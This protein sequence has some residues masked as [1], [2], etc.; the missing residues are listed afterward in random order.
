[1]DNV[2]YTC[3]NGSLK[4]FVRNNAKRHEDILP[5]CTFVRQLE[6]AGRPFPKSKLLKDRQLEKIRSCYHLTVPEPGSNFGIMMCKSFLQPRQQNNFD[7][8]KPKSVV[9]KENDYD[10]RFFSNANAIHEVERFM[11]TSKFEML[12]STKNATTIYMSFV[13]K[14]KFI[15]T[16]DDFKVKILNVLLP[17]SMC[18]YVKEIYVDNISEETEIYFV[19]YVKKTMEDYFLQILCELPDY[20]SIKLIFTSNR[21]YFSDQDLNIANAINFLYCFLTD[22]YKPEKE[23]DN[24][25]ICI[26]MTK[27]LAMITFAIGGRS[28]KRNGLSKCGIGPLA[29]VISEAGIL[30]TAKIN[31][32]L[33]YPDDEKQND[34]DNNKDVSKKQN[35]RFYINSPFER[36]F[37][38]LPVKNGILFTDFQIV[39]NSSKL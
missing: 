38:N 33:E 39:K 3:M 20:P 35:K 10:W 16:I 25:D 4:E 22:R 8:K 13:V 29:F 27:L 26:Y 12:L 30:E 21:F 1:M 36:I 28:L 15:V 18:I 7:I 14:S 37:L 2:I 34:N 5:L 17:Y 23:N 9:E 24:D 11:S 6:A 32:T 19:V 31:G